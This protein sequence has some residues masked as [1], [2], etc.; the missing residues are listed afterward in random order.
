MA[1]IRIFIWVVGVGTLL[2]GVVGVSNIMLVAV[3]ERTREIGIRKALGATPAR[4][5]AWSCRSRS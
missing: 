1:A 5:S 4:S 2:A 3:K